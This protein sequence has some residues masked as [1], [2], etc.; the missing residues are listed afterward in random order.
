MNTQPE[1]P[2]P[3]EQAPPDARAMRAAGMSSAMIREA[4]AKLR[5]ER[6]KKRDA[7]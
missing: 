7:A 5:A 1:E 6:R 3:A 4:L 2:D